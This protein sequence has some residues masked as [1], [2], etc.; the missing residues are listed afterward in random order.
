[1]CRGFNPLFIGAHLLTGGG[2]RDVSPFPVL[3]LFQSPLHRGTSSD[4]MKAL[5][6]MTYA[7]FASFNPLF[8]GAHLLTHYGTTARTILRRMFQSPLHRGTSSDKQ[9]AAV[10]AG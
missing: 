3:P 10:A 4:T 1:M 8:I 7:E 9:A 2:S 6:E 5:H